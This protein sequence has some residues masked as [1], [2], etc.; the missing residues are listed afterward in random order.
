[1]RPLTK[2]LHLRVPPFRHGVLLLLAAMLAFP[3][4]SGAADAPHDVSCSQCH[5]THTAFG[6]QMESLAGNAN[7]CLSCH[8]K[9]GTASAKALGELD[10]AVLPGPGAPTNSLGH[11]TSHRW[12]V[13]PAGHTVVYLGDTV[14]ESHAILVSGTYTGRYS[15]TYTITIT[16]GGNAGVARFDW[17]AQAPALGGG[18]NLLT[19][20]RAVAS[21]DDEGYVTYQYV[22]EPLE[23]GIAL[24]FQN[25]RPSPAFRPGD[26]WQIHVRPDLTVPSNPDLLM[27]EQMALCSTCHN[28]HGQEKTPFDPTAHDYLAGGENHRHF[29]RIDNDR[30]QLCQQC[31]APRFVTNALAGSH[32]VGVFVSSNA[33]F[34][35]PASLPLDRNQGQMWCSTCHQMHYSPSKDGALLRTGEPLALCTQCHKLA[36]PIAGTNDTA[37]HLSKLPGTLW[38]GGQYGSLYPAVTDSAKSGA[39]ANC[40]QVHGWPDAANPTND[41]PQLLVERDENL[42]Y[43]CHDGSPA[44]KDL[45]ATF[46][47]TYS[48]PVALAGRHSALEDGQPAAYSVTNRHAE[49]ADCHNPHALADDVTP[50]TKPAAPG[51]L[52]GVARVAVNNLGSNSVALTF[53]GPSDPAPVKEYEVC[54][55]CHS[56]WTTQPVGQADY[57][58]KFNE[59]NPSFHPVE[60][61][62]KNINIRS[63]AF[64]NGWAG[65]QTMYCSDCHTSD[66][67]AIRGPHGSTNR[68]ILKKPYVAS[69]SKRTMSS[70]ELCFDCHRYDTYANNSAS[71]T[72]KNY[73]RFNGSGWGWP[74]EDIFG[75]G[76]TYHVGVQRISCYTCHETHGSTSQPFLIALG[77]NP[78]INTFV[79]TSTGGRCN[80][81]C[82]GTVSYSVTYPR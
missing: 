72:V 2:S 46:A 17:V 7:L 4:S 51:S 69:A 68:Y 31:H 32:P 74:M 6:N 64:V 33:L 5:L 10:Q 18:T 3:S 12:D 67:P 22:P 34:Q 14:D 13:H 29:M 81:T 50:P 20:H 49:C 43:T 58:A 45:R 11:G 8:V 24:W 15:K 66:D 53:R 41:Y 9:G 25:F 36:N 82:H 48:H 27:I 19:G 80:A 56:S 61:Q 77:R 63:N 35:P 1:M 65:A 16:T 62:G 23:E 55:T 47:K 70:G 52:K 21:V 78:G 76:H 54:F 37:L 28:Q 79:P 42:C 75:G 38:P 59:K 60:A 26:R 73:S 30:D 57:A 39:C 40:H 71:T 44:A